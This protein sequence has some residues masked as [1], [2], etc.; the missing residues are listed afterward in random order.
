MALKSDKVYQYTPS[1]SESGY[2]N[3]VENNLFYVWV[4]KNNM[5]QQ[6]LTNLRKVN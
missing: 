1:V 3:I 4:I 5:H 2:K 6:H